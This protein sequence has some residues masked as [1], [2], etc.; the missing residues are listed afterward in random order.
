MACLLKSRIYQENNNFIVEMKAVRGIVEHRRA[1]SGL[2]SAL[3]KTTGRAILSFSLAYT[4]PIVANA[5]D[6]TQYIIHNVDKRIEEVCMPS[7]HHRL[8]IQHFPTQLTQECESLRAELGRYKHLEEHYYSDAKDIFSLRDKGAKGG[9]L[10]EDERRKMSAIISDLRVTAG[11]LNKSA[12]SV[13]K[14]EK[15]IAW[16]LDNHFRSSNSVDSGMMMVC[17]SSYLY[18]WDKKQFNNCVDLSILLNDRGVIRYA[19]DPKAIDCGRQRYGDSEAGNRQLFIKVEEG[20][21]SSR[22]AQS[23]SRQAEIDREIAEIQ[24]DVVS[25]YESGKSEQDG[26]CVAPAQSTLSKIGGFLFGAALFVT[27]V[28]F[29]AAQIRK[30]G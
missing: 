7:D 13:E 2:A 3:R 20:R 10:S 5:I 25:Y 18:V 4:L 11:A 16:E 21:L 8:A 6:D 26:T 19:E 9:G 17:A 1:E 30:E 27:V 23:R 12:N 29:V 28:L 15:E 14:T 22:I 24:R